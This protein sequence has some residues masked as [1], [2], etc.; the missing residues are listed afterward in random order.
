MKALRIGTA[1]WSIPRQ[2]ASHL[3]GEGTHL[4]RYSQFFRCAEINSSFY[5]SPRPSTWARWAASVPADFRFSVKAPKAVTHESSLDCSPE[6]LQSFLK[7]AQTLGTKIGPIL[8]QL[9]PKLIFTESRA[10]TFF[11]LLRDLY[12]DPVVLEPRNETWFAPEADHLLKNFQ[13]SRAAADPPRTPQATKPGGWTHLIYYRLHGSPR[14]YYS[15]YGEDYLLNLASSLRGHPEASEV[16]CI[17]D[18]TASGAALGDALA[19]Q[20]LTNT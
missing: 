17:F 11:T 1:G 14:M 13:I 12:P 4:D 9:P 18:N 15:A 16:W 10:Q 7:E 19:L 3:H 20:R 8:F 6:L 5:R 2:H